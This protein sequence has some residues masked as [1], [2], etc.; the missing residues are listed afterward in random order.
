MLVVAVVAA[1]ATLLSS[2]N[3]PTNARIDAGPDLRGGFTSLDVVGP[4]VYTHGFTDSRMPWEGMDL[5]SEAG[6]VSVYG[7]RP[8]RIRTVIMPDTIY[9]RFA[10]N[11]TTDFQKMF[12]KAI[13]TVGGLAFKKPPTVIV[14][15]TDFG[16]SRVE[17][18]RGAMLFIIVDSLDHV[19]MNVRMLRIFENELITDRLF[20]MGI[21]DP[22]LLLG[23]L[24]ILSQG[25]GELQRHI[26]SHSVSRGGRSVPRKRHR[27]PTP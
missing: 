25:G 20:S 26:P 8:M 21:P 27:A 22:W 5:V 4:W 1:I 11:P 9:G 16:Y 12:M 17:D 19:K 10:E 13:H 18:H 6:Y 15:M 3:T 14:I 23:S 2:H 24:P 7:Q